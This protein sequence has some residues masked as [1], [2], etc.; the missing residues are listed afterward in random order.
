MDGN[1]GLLHLVQR[2]GDLGG[3]DSRPKI[4]RTDENVTYLKLLI[5]E[6]R[7]LTLMLRHFAKYEVN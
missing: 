7:T 3:A 2:G 5:S 1:R 6:N 4:A